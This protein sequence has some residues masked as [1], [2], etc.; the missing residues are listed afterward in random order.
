MQLD[1]RKL[2][3][4]KALPVCAQDSGKNGPRREV[5]I[6]HAQTADLTRS[7]TARRPHRAVGVGQRAARLGEKRPSRLSER[8]AP[9]RARQEHHAQFALEVLDLLAQRRLHDVEPQRRAPKVQFLGDGHEVA[10]MTEFHRRYGLSLKIGSAISIITI[11][12]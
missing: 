10:N 9:F 12:D 8:H 1:Q 6:A 7:R 11:N 2:Y 5:D 3:F 4:G